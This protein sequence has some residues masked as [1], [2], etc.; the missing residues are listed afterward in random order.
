MMANEYIAIHETRMIIM[1]FLCKDSIK[2]V[3]VIEYF[4]LKMRDVSY[5]HFKKYIFLLFYLPLGTG[6]L[7]LRCRSKKKNNQVL[8]CLTGYYFFSLLYR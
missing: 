2:Y 6:I 1:H 5:I 3:L 8:V 4:E 7:V